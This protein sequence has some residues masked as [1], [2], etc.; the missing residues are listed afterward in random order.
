MR[1][2]TQNGRVAPNDGVLPRSDRE[3]ADEEKGEE[4]ESTD[5]GKINIRDFSFDSAKNSESL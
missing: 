1:G 5:S 3:P 2:C 4:V